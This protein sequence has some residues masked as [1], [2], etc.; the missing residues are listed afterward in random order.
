M[1]S[2]TIQNLQNPALDDVIQIIHDSAPDVSEVSM[3]Y[4]N[5]SNTLI[6]CTEY[7]RDRD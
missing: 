1:V 3:Q 5:A 4:F 2:R 7:G 6:V